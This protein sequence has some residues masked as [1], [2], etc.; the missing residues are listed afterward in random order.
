[1]I[2]F[3]PPSNYRCYIFVFPVFALYVPLSFV[4]FF[5]I[6][7][8][9]DSQRRHVKKP[10]EEQE[11]YRLCKRK[12]KPEDPDEVSNYI[13]IVKFY[14]VCQIRCSS[15][16]VF[17][18]ARTGHQNIDCHRDHLQFSLNVPFFSL[19]FFR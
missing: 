12:R 18:H 14:S 17:I 2:D 11:Q 5:M 15:I 7:L 8:S 16:F 6:V 4:N 19:N 13:F 9:F 1:M 3:M 10:T